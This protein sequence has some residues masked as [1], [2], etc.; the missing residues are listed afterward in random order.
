MPLLLALALTILFAGLVAKLW[1]LVIASLLLGLVFQLIWLWPR[2][3]LAER[4]L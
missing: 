1:W 2:P 4:R 3:Q